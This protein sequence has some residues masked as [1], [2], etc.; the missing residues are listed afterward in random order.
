M[1]QFRQEFL[2]GTVVV[3]LVDGLGVLLDGQHAALLLV[4]GVATPVRFGGAGMRAG[5]ENGEAGEDTG[6][7]DRTGHGD[8]P[9]EWTGASGAGKR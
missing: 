3:A 8:L 7:G 2:E 1:L 9:G 4:A 6:N 5:G